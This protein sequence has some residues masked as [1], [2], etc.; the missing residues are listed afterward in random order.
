MTTDLDGLHGAIKRGDII[1]VRKY[2]ASGG[3][4]STPDRNGW[5]PLESAAYRGNA[6]LVRLLL[7]AGADA[8]ATPTP[9]GMTPL[10]LAAMAGSLPAVKVLLKCGAR[11]DHGGVSTAERLRGWGYGDRTRILEAIEHARGDKG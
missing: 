3:S 1:A 7:D 11:T 8:N 4:V 10:E 2:I 5:T 9:G 6:V